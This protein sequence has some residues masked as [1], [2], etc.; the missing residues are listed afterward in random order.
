MSVSGNFIKRPVL[1]TVCTIVIM[2]IGG[3]CIPL[4]P[5]NY[6][7]DISPVQIRVS[8][9]YTGADVQTVENTVT[10]IL[11][12]EINGVAGMDYISSE[13][14][15]GTS[16]IS[17]YFPPGS[18]KDISQVNVQNRVAQAL[19]KLPSTVQQLGVTT[20]ATSSSI[21]MVYGIYGENGEYDDIFISDY[22]DANIVDTL[23]RI[24]GVGDVTVFGSKQ[25]AMR[26]WLDPSALAARGLTI[27][28][29]SNALRTQSVV[30]G[31]GAIGQAPVPEGQN[32]EL[33]IRIQGRFTDTAEFENLVVKTLPDGGL[34]R[35][36]DVGYAKIGG[37][38]YA[39]NALINGQ[40][41]V[42]IAVS[43]LP[44]SNALDVGNN[45]K[46]VIAELSKKF[47]PGMTASLV[48]DTTE[49]I[50]VS[51]Q[52]VLITL[53][54]AI[55]LVILVIFIFL[56]D[57]RTT[58]IPAVAIPVALVGA[59][60]F[61]F[62]F[63][64]SLN[65]LTLFGLILATGLVVDDAIVIV[66]AVTTKIN[67][68]LLPKQ[69]SLAVMDE[70]AGA[71]VSTSL[72]LMAVFIPVAFFPGTTGALYQQFALIIA[73]SVAVSTFNALSFSPSMAA[74]LLK[75]KSTEAATNHSGRVNPL[76]WFFNKFNQAQDWLIAKYRSVVALFVRMR[77]II[78]GVFVLGLIA[79]YQMFM[80]VPSGFVPNE[81]QGI[82]LGIVQGP[83]GVSL[84]YTD[85]VIESVGETISSIPEVE[86]YFAA[87]GAS[88]EGAGPN[89]G[90]FFAK[91]KPWD[92][93]AGEGEDVDS[94]LQKINGTFYQNQEAIAAGFNPPPIPGFS[95]TGGI[96]LQ[97][98]DQTGG[99]YS[100][101]DFLGSAREVLARANAEE[102]IGSASTQFTAG[103]PQLEINLDRNQL[104][105]LN[106]DFQ[107][108]L[109]TI[110]A[111]IGSQYVND[112]T[113]GAR[114]Y[115]VFVQA[116]GDFRNSPEDLQSLYVRSRDN[117][118]IP[119]GAI[120]QVNSVTGPQIIY[121][122]NG[123]RTI[124]FQAQPADGFSSGQAI[125][126]LNES[127]AEV[128]FP[129]LESD[130]IGLAKEEIA[131]G[132]LGLLVFAFGIIMVFLTLSAQYESYIDPIII[133]LTVPLALLGALSFVAVRD[134]QNDVYVQVALVMLIGLASK[135]AIL[136]V[137]F[138]NQEKEAGATIVEAA[139]RAGEARFRAILMTAVSSLVGFF[140]LVISTGAGSASRRVIGTA[141]FGGL[142]V[143]TVL[144]FLVVPVLYVVIK[145]LEAN[146]LKDESSSGGSDTLDGG[147]K[148]GGIE[149][150]AAGTGNVGS[151]EV[152]F[153][154]VKIEGEDLI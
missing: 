11:E 32:F 145:S 53:M 113:L 131:A 46:A 146:F 150:A 151:P 137:E 94:I 6:L 116:Q 43:Q 28:D 16:N 33:P 122:Y 92:E 25:N 67:E 13:T 36:R 100:I 126:A 123:F 117:Q 127:L 52:E 37:E 109:Q 119:L 147:S 140:P 19:P 129:G 101:D 95:A 64:F 86:G 17:V 96:E 65:S 115:K 103:A 130:W 76:Q 124:K 47:P 136:I 134:M 121:H 39:T 85:D 98:Q 73:F 80:I 144:S 41:G 74:I 82:L 55:G 5:I 112:F 78:I 26:L 142:L 77:Y 88:L 54:Q 3:V 135:N 49:F 22:V 15:A 63:G 105:A 107:Q 111:T 60:G 68:G 118:M 50:Q 57:W 29:V 38:N 71:V 148:G 21:L 132:N 84:G 89:R 128:S 31:A 102:A 12:R 9:F 110:G 154:P 104:E 58:I 79:T 69:A 87:S 56:Q 14:Y 139:K 143:S 10:T 125:A 120:A 44:G 35:L 45:T 91:L 48:Y 97:F 20:K 138:A 23:K 93:R 114:G 51:I 66:E 24:K 70:I 75:P 83:D 90:M 133:L 62:A 141:L 72:V 42:A 40:Q 1:T 81:D 99:D 149:L 4:L 59:L 108:A 153:P 61:A 106:I 2:L 7:P 18:D 30:V 34:V 152:V 8:S 27:L